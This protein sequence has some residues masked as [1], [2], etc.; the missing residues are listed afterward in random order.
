LSIRPVPGAPEA[1]RLMTHA[2]W[3][4]PRWL[5]WL[6][7]AWTGA[8]GSAPR[9]AEPGPLPPA[10]AERASGPGAVGAPVDRRLADRLAAL[11][12]SEAETAA[13][14]G[15]LNPAEQDELAAR[16]DELGVGGDPVAAGVAIAIIV[17][18]FVILTL[19][20]IGRR[21]ISRPSEPEG[22]QP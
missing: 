19:E 12:L 6:L 7:V 20:L 5:V 15:R 1:G 18:M 13:L 11:G 14:W 21:V 22:G 16:A 9:L 4:R 2:R 8:I 17:A 10:R 3:R